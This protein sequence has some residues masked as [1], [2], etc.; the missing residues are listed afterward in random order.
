METGE[1]LLIVSATVN[2]PLAVSWDVSGLPSG[3]YLAAY[4]VVLANIVPTRGPVARTLVGNTAINLATTPS[5]EVPAGET[6]CYVLRYGDDLVFDLAFEPG[7]NLVSLPIEPTAPTVASV[8]GGCVGEP[9][10]CAWQGQDY[11]TVAEMHAC[12]AYWVYSAETNVLLVP[13]LPAGQSHLTLVRGW[14]LCGVEYPQAVPADERI[15]GVPW[16]WHPGRSRYSGAT[17]LV[18][19]VGYWFN[20]RE[21][22]AIPVGGEQ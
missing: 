10:V 7:W 8:L 4:E 21:D 12:V 15:I 19:G 18:P 6:R 11:A 14:N 9:S 16:L 3:K 5:L 20:V 2:A 1:F 17:E 13:G 22:A